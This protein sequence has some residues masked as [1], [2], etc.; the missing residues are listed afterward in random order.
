MA[1]LRNYLYGYGSGGA[2]EPRDFTVFNTNDQTPTNGGRC[3]LWTVPANVNCAIF[4]IWSAGGDGG[5]ACCCMQ[6]GGAGGGVYAIKT[7]TISPG[8]TF[9]ICAAGSGCCMQNEAGR[10]GDPSWVCSNGGG[11]QPTW[12]MCADGGREVTRSVRCFYYIGCYTCCSSCFCCSIAYGADFFIGG[13]TGVGMGTQHC[14]DQ[15]HQYAGTAPMTTGPRLG[16][17]GCCAW[18]G[19][20]SNIHFPG[21]GGHSS[22]GHPGGCCCGTPGGGGM[23]YVLYF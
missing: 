23:V 14:I 21:G 16:P 4:E 2:V 12:Y 5:G 7:C 11:G 17:N 22:Q 10:A 18:G 1:S 3:C 15:G 13:T 8:Q 20:C 9:T 6:G 19:S